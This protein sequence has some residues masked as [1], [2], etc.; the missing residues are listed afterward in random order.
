MRV[1]YEALA[2][3]RHVNDHRDA[4]EIVRRAD[5]D[6]VGLILDSFHTLGRGIDPGSIRRIPGDRIFFVQLADA[7]AISMDPLYWSRHFRNMPGEGDLPVTDFMRAV[8]ATGYS[9]PIS[10]EIFNDQFRGGSARTIAQDGYRSLVGLMDEVQRTEPEIAVDMPTLPP[11]VPVRDTA[12]V[13]LPHRA[14]RSPCSKHCWKASASGGR[15]GTFPSEYRFGGKAKSAS[16][17]TPR[18]RAM[19]ARYG[20]PAARRSA[21]SAFRSPRPPTRHRA[22]WRSVQNRSP[23]RSDQANCRSRQSG[24]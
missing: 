2:W 22:P 16:F 6:A 13:E 15:D 21:I 11:P 14:K 12:F 20:R 3:G 18:P 1:G 9:G 17:S 8:A 5:H 4:W 7:P 10:L 23:S 24:E 19:P